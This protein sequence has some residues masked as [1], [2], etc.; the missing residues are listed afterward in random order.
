MGKVALLYIN[1]DR[2]PD[3][4]KRL[5]ASI[6]ANEFDTIRL[7]AV[8]ARDLSDKTASELVS[9]AEDACW[10]SHLVAYSYVVQHNLQ[11]AVILEDDAD[12]DARKFD[13]E[14]LGV[15]FQFMAA[16]NLQVFQLGYLQNQYS[17]RKIGPLLESVRDLLLGR[18]A[19]SGS[20]KKLTKLAV[21]DSFRSGAHAY[22]VTLE[23]ARVL[24]GLNQPTTF[25]ADNFLGLLANSRNSKIRVARMHTSLVNQWSRRTLR[26]D[27]L[28]SDIAPKA[29]VLR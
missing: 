15:L 6:P 4:R 12:F 13:Q 14:S 25:P 19:R 1:L 22:V 5:E 10:R 24:Q 18:Y 16:N 9:K 27:D 11:Y 17:L 23:G 20:S 28:D 29:Q 26:V 7:T 3:R 21:L 2:R 8:D